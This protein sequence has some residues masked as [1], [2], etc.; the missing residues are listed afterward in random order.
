M[1]AFMPRRDVILLTAGTV[2]LLANTG[3][4]SSGDQIPWPEKSAYQYRMEIQVMTNER[5]F[6]HSPVSTAIDFRELLDKAGDSGR[7]RQISL[8]AVDGGNAEAKLSPVPYKLVGDFATTDAGYLHWRLPRADAT[9]FLLY[10]NADEMAAWRSPSRPN[11]MVGIGDAFPGHGATGVAEMAPLHST[12]WHVDWNGDGLRDMIGFGLRS[13][14]FGADLDKDLGNAVFFYP[15]STSP[16]PGRP[17]VFGRPWRIKDVNGD[18]LQ[19]DYLYQNFFPTDW[20]ED[21][22]L[23]FFAF[24]SQRNE[25]ALY[26]NTGTRDRNGLYLLKP[27]RTLM[28]LPVSDYR[29]NFPQLYAKPYFAHRGARFVDWEGDGD[30]DLIVSFLKVNKIGTQDSSKGVIPYGAYLIIFEV[31]ENIDTN[32]E[33][34]PVFNKPFVIHEERGVPITSCT[35]APGGPAYLDWDGDGDFDLLFADMTNRPLE[36][37]RLMFCENVGTRSKPLF[38]RKIPILDAVSSPQVVDWNGDGRFDLIAGGEFFENINPRSGRPAVEPNTTPLGTYH[39]RPHHFPKL[40]SRGLAQ[41]EDP[42]LLSFFTISVDWDGDGV[43]D[44][45]GGYRS[46]I[47]LYRNTGTLREPVFAPRELIEAD[48]KPI[49]MPN[50]LDPQAD[51]PSHWGPQGP[52]EA[53]W[54]WANPSVADWDGDGDLDL[55]VTGQRWQVQYFEN[56]GSRAKPRL[57]PGREVR[58]DG[59]P[60]EFSWRSKVALG[61]LDG[62]RKTEFVVT[63]HHDNIFTAYETATDQ[64]DPSKLELVRDFKLQLT[65]EGFVKGWYGGQNNNGDNH[66]QLVDWDGD[67]DLDLFNGSLWAVWYY[68]NVG[69]PTS[70]EFKARGKVKG[71]SED[72]HT[73]NHAGSFDAADWSGD[74]R[75]DLVMGTECPS[76][77]PIGARLHLFDRAFIDDQLPETRFGTL[78]TRKKP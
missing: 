40:A 57:A 26:E 41:V 13:W 42:Q 5:T 64:P 49:S 24:P 8:Y 17:P 12:Y 75:L 67:G 53:D 48:G 43:L 19:R 25:L 70:P 4:G 9:R 55:F 18:D 54:G 63:S 73:F 65:Q 71:G 56:T 50:W 68:E 28:K 58:C 38:I 20:D 36:G 7:P 45:L 6:D 10:F 47:A 3:M 35:P 16:A 11:A 52:G 66:S 34:L 31:F 69:T 44:L 51:E 2:A 30:R 22:D 32:D 39:P 59:D 72:L 33:G 61:D 1:N 27:M 62:D 74:G 21:G 37:G 77:Q 15:A 78:E 76:D 14:E 23:D 60:H 29:E 46:N